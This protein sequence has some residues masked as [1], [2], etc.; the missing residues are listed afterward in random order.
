MGHQPVTWGGAPRW[1][2]RHLRE[3]AAVGLKRQRFAQRRKACGYSQEGLAERLGV[4]RSTVARWERGTTDP[5]PWARPEILQALRLSAEELDELLTGEHTESGSTERLDHVLRNPA[6]LG[7]VDVANVHT[8]IQRLGEQY[9]RAPSTALLAEVGQYLGH[10]AFLGDAATDGRILSAFYTM[11]AE[12]ATLMG[13]LV[14]DASQRCAHRSAST[15]YDQAVNAARK[16]RDPATEGHALLRKSF[17]ALY[18]QRDARAGLALARRTA[19]TTTGT[20]HVLTGLALL[21]SAE[22][23]AMLGD[24]GPCEKDLETAETEFARVDAADVASDLYSPTQFGRLA[25]SCY[26]ALGK[27]RRARSFLEEAASHSGTPTKSRAIVLGNLALT[28][29]RQRDFG[30]AT[31]ALHEAIDA[32]TPTRDGGGLN[33]VFQAG[34]ELRPWRHVRAVGDVYDRLLSLMTA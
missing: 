9:D 13:Q 25:G 23:H 16:V 1:S 19:D 34:R 17:I 11:E 28:H 29:I 33:V 8:Q 15:Y 12:A 4:E 14:W 18:G 32:V 27:Y 22:A 2:V 3:R 7:L 20:S 30:G 10:I 26:L 6:G 5:Q 24:I 21:H 31:S